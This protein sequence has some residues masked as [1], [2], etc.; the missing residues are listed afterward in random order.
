MQFTLSWFTRHADPIIIEQLGEH[1]VS[2]YALLLGEIY[3]YEVT[4]S[5]ETHDYNVRDVGV[6]M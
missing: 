2:T 5:D 6:R 3:G 1:T 4:L